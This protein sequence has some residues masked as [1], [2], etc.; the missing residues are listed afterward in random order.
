MKKKIIRYSLYL[1]FFIILVTAVSIC[2]IK[3]KHKLIDN[4]IASAKPDTQV[5]SIYYNSLT[6]REQLLYNA[7]TYAASEHHE[8]SSVI[9]SE[10]SMEEFQDILSCIRADR[11][12]LFYI[13]YD[14]L[15]LHKRTH[16]TKV[17]MKYIADGKK[18]REMCREYEKVVEKALEGIN[19]SMSDFE[20]ELVLCHYVTDK[21]TYSA[22]S[23]DELENTAYGALVLGRASCDGYA[24]AVKD[25]LNKAFIE[26]FVIYGKAK[27][28]EHVWNMVNIDG[29]YYHLDV[30]WN[31]SDNKADDGLRFHGYFNLSDEKIKLDH[32]FKD[33]KDIIPK[34]DSDNCYYKSI[35]CYTEDEEELEEIL[36]NALCKS[37]EEEREYIELEYIFSKE[38]T[39][40]KPYFTNAA[41]RVNELYGED[42]LYN[43]F[44]VRPAADNSNAITIRIFYN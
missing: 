6:Y 39:L 10:Y 13:D 40:L 44:N 1:L 23:A 34:A 22:V 41:D 28:N 12:D 37:V 24:F 8:M 32:H 38:N 29:E 16:Q 26:S 3:I 43:S 36:F 19:D 27:D 9:D 30:T 33:E 15:V 14:A 11:P 4:E 20:K 31:D 35:D 21:C 2:V 5:Y 7:V 42:I 17:E 25:L 18:M